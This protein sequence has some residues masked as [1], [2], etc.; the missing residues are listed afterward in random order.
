MLTRL[1]G[2]VCRLGK[3]DI[4]AFLCCWLDSGR[5]LSCCEEGQDGK[6]GGQVTIHG[7]SLG[8]WAVERLAD[9]HKDF[10]QGF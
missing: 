5:R 6:E 7:V 2:Q 4:E 8:A 9:A 3:L 10:E 1:D